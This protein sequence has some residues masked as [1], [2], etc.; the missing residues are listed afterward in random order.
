MTRFRFCPYH[1]CQI[2]SFDYEIH[3]NNSHTIT[4]GPAWPGLKIKPEVSHTS[5]D[6]AVSVS[7]SLDPPPS[8]IFY[9]FHH[10]LFY[11]LSNIIESHHILIHDLNKILT[12]NSQK[13]IVLSP[14]TSIFEKIPLTSDSSTSS[15]HTLCKNS[16]ISFMLMKPLLSS[17]IALNSS[18]CNMRPMFIICSAAHTP[19]WPCIRDDPDQDPSQDSTELYN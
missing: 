14:V 10:R 5:A 6:A 19:H 11:V 15:S 7:A 12:S 17:S 4:P 18:W 8:S 2:F 16:I 9:F 1:T 13:S 3:L